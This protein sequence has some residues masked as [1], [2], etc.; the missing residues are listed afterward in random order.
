MPGDTKQTAR[1]TAQTAPL[2]VPANDTVELPFVGKIAAGV[3]ILALEDAERTV[4]VPPHFVGRGDH[5]ALEVE[6]ESMK[7]AGILDGDII[8]CRRAD[9]ARNNEIVVALV[10]QEEATLKRLYKSGEQVELIPENEEFETRSF[11]PDRVEVQGVLVGLVRTY[12]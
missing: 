8:I 4:A 7:D 5:F 11:G 2:P 12:H 10:D 1:N 9:T 3:P 6:G